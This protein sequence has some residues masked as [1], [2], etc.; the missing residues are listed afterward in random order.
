MNKE[1]WLQAAKDAGIEEF[2]I[3]DQNT[4]STSIRLYEGSVDGFTIS[5]CRGISLRGIY[6]GKMGICFLEESDDS[7]LEF[8]LNQIKQNATSITSEDEAEIYAGAQEYPDVKEKENHMLDLPSEEKINLLKEIEQEL[9][10]HDERITQVMSTNYGQVEMCRAIDNTK[11]VHLG[12]EHHA[13]YI[14][15]AVMAKDGD[16]TKIASDWKYIYD[17]QDLNPKEFAQALCA[18]VIAKLH[19][20]SVESG[21]YPVLLQNEAMSDLLTALS[22]MFHGESIYKG[23][24]ILKDKLG[25]TVFDKRISIVDDPLLES[26]Y[27]SAA[28]DDEGV[29]CYRKYLVEQGVFKTCLHN[30]KSA[31]LMNTVST[32]NGFKGG[33][34]SSVDISPTNLY[35]EQGDVSYDD[36]IGS[37]D[38]GIII[39][40]ITGLHAGLNPI[41]TEFSLQSSGFLV[42]DG[43]IVRP[44]NLI[45]VAGNFM[46]AMKN[47]RMIGED[48]KMGSSGI[49]SPSILFES[50]AI[51]GK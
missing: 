27:E 2:E 14:T 50:L 15:C 3:Y 40:E 41:S 31:K 35:I 46:E 4:K 39:T 26:G 42:E 20:E 17:K 47:I 18:K 6:N 28:F 37:M 21:N 33:Y 38:K 36:M 13:S 1:L 9:K 8:A 19:G 7:L 44:V 24:S 25:E 49:G 32:G 11:G 23:V 22:G 29:A 45:T 43:K 16:D 30:L 10:N 5:E 12:D 51:S 48:L 34:A